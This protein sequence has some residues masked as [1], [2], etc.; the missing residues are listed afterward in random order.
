[1]KTKIAEKLRDGDQ[2]IV[3]RGTHAGK[4]GT[5]RDVHSSKTGHIT[6]TIEQKNG[7][8]F[9]TPGKNAVVQAGRQ[10]KLAG[11]QFVSQYAFVFMAIYKSTKMHVHAPELIKIK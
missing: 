1:M 3:A 9:K 7:V 10:S 8:R 6:I 11:L 2:C 5:V 4:S